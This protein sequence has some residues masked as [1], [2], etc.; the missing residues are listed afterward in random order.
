MVRAPPLVH[1]LRGCIFGIELKA[2][3]WQGKPVPGY[4]VQTSAGTNIRK[5][6]PVPESSL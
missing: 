2:S 4:A 6:V 5:N 1:N 3:R